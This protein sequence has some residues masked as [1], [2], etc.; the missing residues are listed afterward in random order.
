MA[1]DD[2]RG[3]RNNQLRRKVVEE[4]PL[5]YDSQYGA[6][7]RLVDFDLEQAIPVL[8][9]TPAVLS[10]LLD[11]LP[12]KWTVVD[13]GP[14]TWSPRQVVAH[15]IH[16]ER[17]DWIPRARIILKQGK[18][19]KFDPFDRFA[20]LNP[21]RPLGDLLAEFD[22]LRAESVATLR[23]WNL[24]DKDLELTGGHPEFGD[25][26]MRQLLAT[27]VVHDLSHIAQITRTMARAYTEA[28]GPWTAYF[29]VLQ[30]EIRQ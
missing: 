9:R 11:E 24:K 7:E 21:Q 15:L 28:V 18:Y 25:V 27:W 3:R 10:D 20:E 4:C 12:E 13:E 1:A 23:G 19:R 5:A 30:R 26:T 6:Q 2:A 14:E 29:R 16:G 8:E 17:T 22:R